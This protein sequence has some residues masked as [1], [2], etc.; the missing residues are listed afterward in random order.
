M[1]STLLH[2]AVN[3]GT[4]IIFS[5]DSSSICGNVGN[6]VV[7]V[8]VVGHCCLNVATSFKVALKCLLMIE[9]WQ[10]MCIAILNNA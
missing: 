5:C 10:M 2:R 6:V 1:R 7:V 8:D 4:L 9:E 3:P